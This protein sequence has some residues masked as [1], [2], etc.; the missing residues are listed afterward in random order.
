[1][2]LVS[3]FRSGWFLQI[4]FKI[5]GNFCFFFRTAL[6]YF[7]RGNRGPVKIK[8][9]VERSGLRQSG[10]WS[11]L[12]KII[13]S[14]CKLVLN[15]VYSEKEGG[16][17]AATVEYSLGQWRSML[18]YVFAGVFDSRISVSAQ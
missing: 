12:W 14:Y 11:H 18:S 4:V 9:D 10:L 2:I 7:N 17:E 1:M 3:D 8:P 16:R 6:L 13:V 15:I 5:F